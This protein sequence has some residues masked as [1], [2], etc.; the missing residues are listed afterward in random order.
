[1]RDFARMNPP[2]F[3][4]SKVEE[5]PQELIDETY[6]ILYAMGFTTSEKAELATNQLKDVAQTWSSNGKTIGL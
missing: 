1:M 4:G 2:N 5:V 6:K 3:Y